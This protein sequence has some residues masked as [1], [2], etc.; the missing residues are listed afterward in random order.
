MPCRAYFAMSLRHSVILRYSVLSN[1]L[2][3]RLTNYYHAL[4]CVTQ[5]INEYSCMNDGVNYDHANQVTL[6][7]N[8]FDT[9][10]GQIVMH[11][12]R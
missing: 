11:G 2:R 1:K 8:K 12:V 3:F 4:L 9:I 6:N 5:K 10:K 7:G